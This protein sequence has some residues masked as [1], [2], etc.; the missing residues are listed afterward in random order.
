MTTLTDPARWQPRL[1]EELRKVRGPGAVF[2]VLHGDD[3]VE[4][5][6]G[7]A[8]LDTGTPV[9]T[10][11]VFHVASISKVYTATLAMQLVDEGKLDLDVPVRTYVPEFRVADP[12]ATEHVTARHL[13][14]HT[15]GLNGDKEDMFGRGD[16]VLARYMESCAT[17]DQV[18][19][20]GA[21]FSYC[22]A[23]FNLLG[24]VIEV[25]R[26][27]TFDAVL[28]DHLFGPLGSRRTGTL[29]EEVVWYPVANGHRTEDE[30]TTVSYAWESERSH[31]PAGGVVT[32]AA[33]ML[34][35]ARMHIDGGVAPD[36]TR[37]LAPETVAAMAEPQVEVPDPSYGITHW[38][39]G[40]EMLS[41][42]GMPTVIGHGG[43]LF[44]YHSYLS[45]CP[46]ARL[47]V[48]LLM[49]GDGADRVADPLLREVLG[50]VG[51]TL[52]PLPVPP[53]TPPEVDMERMAGTYET[54]AVRITFT[55]ADDHLHARYRIV[56]ETL[57]ALIPES[58]RE[59]ELTFLPTGGSRFLT[60]TDPHD[61]WTSALFYESDG[62]R[63]LHMGLRALRASDSEPVTAA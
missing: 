56:D 23:G 36:G 43:D 28:R 33:D 47:A 63:Y 60:R 52:P 61:Q 39:L 13:L 35:F 32:T 11:T 30:K 3:M 59:R 21:T 24:R 48:V 15:S 42:P 22:N 49:N 27:K 25:L 53:E 4:C 26:G 44:G 41:S 37:V 2:A 12:H 31:A 50:E 10:G 34:A 54:V 18:H 16:D 14:A 19:P 1:E 46:S 40:W 55:P 29:A 5:A 45:I 8:N 9:E 51:V 62:D 38:G 57:A 6:A 7:V 58:Q 17:L 20:L